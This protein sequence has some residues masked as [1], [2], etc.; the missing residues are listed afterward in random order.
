MESWCMKKQ[1]VFARTTRAQKLM[2]V[3]AAQ[4]VGLM[5]G[6]LGDRVE[7]SPAIKQGDIGISL[8]LFGSEVT[9][10]AADMILLNDDLASLIDG[11]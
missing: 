5:V 9:K 1:V 7:D 8:N 4:R 3:Q 2:V 6:V 10:D 11:V